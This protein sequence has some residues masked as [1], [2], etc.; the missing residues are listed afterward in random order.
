MKKTICNVNE[1]WLLS[2]NHTGNFFFSFTIYCRT[3]STSTDISNLQCKVGHALPN[4]R[5][6]N[7][8][9]SQHFVS[10][11]RAT[12]H[13]GCGTHLAWNW[14]L[15][16]NRYSA[17]FHKIYIQTIILTWCMKKSCTQ[18]PLFLFCYLLIQKKRWKSKTVE[19]KEKILQFM[20]HINPKSN[21]KSTL[22]RVLCNTDMLCPQNY[23]KYNTKGFG[24][25]V[26]EVRNLG[27]VALITGMWHT[28]P[29]TNKTLV[30]Q[31]G[32]DFFFFWSQ[33]S[34]WFSY[35]TTYMQKSSIKMI[36]VNCSSLMK[37]WY[38]VMV[39]GWLTSVKRPQIGL[40]FK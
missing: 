17:L 28:P 14:F 27:L 37:V 26:V 10:H 13:L 18:R 19:E 35:F 25:H 7:P 8:E 4:H 22:L 11:H 20:G 36:I 5:T 3:V 30:E 34:V 23:K 31:E 32:L 6:A 16:S 9:L 38:W 39:S 21:W 40:L 2:F 24:Q 33:F 29:N 12:C 15:I 1:C